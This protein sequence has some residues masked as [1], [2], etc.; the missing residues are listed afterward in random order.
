MIYSSRKVQVT[1]PF[2]ESDVGLLDDLRAAPD[3][4]RAREYT[5]EEDYGLYRFWGIKTVKT[6]EQ[7]YKRTHSYLKKRYDELQSEGM[8]S[9]VQ[10]LIEE[11]EGD[12]KKT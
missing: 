9:Y 12:K 6:F 8:S 10:S 7:A 2:K 1:F 11:F 4:P 3:T 5:R